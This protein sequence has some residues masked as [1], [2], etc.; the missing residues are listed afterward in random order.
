MASSVVR[1]RC[2][3]PTS[4][5]SPTA[6]S[7]GALSPGSA[8]QYFGWHRYT[9]FLSNPEAAASVAFTVI[10]SPHPILSAPGAH[11]SYRKRGQTGDSSLGLGP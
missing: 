7:W 9:V 3:C 2:N 1:W 8:D 6:R 11:L 10:D 4:Q 5:L